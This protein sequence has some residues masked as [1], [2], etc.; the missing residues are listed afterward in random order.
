MTPAQVL[1]VAVLDR[2][3]RK[4][5][6]KVD[7]GNNESYKATMSILGNPVGT[8]KTRIITALV[9]L[10]KDTPE[11]M[12]SNIS[13]NEVVSPLLSIVKKHDK[14]VPCTLVHVGNDQISVQ[15][16]RSAKLC[17]LR[18][19]TVFQQK[20]T[21]DLLELARQ[22]DMLIVRGV[23]F[24]RLLED[25]GDIHWSMFVYD[26]PDC[27]VNPQFKT[28]IPTRFHMLVT[29][30]WDQLWDVTY[31]RYNYLK[32][33]GMKEYDQ[34]EDYLQYLVVCTAHEL[35]MPV[36]RTHN[37]YFK[38]S[39]ADAMLRGLFSH[40]VDRLIDS[41]NWKGVANLLGSQVT[42]KTLP[43]VATESIQAELDKA[44]ESGNRALKVLPAFEEGSPD[45]QSMQRQ[46]KKSKL[47][48]ENFMARM[49]ILK[50][51]IVSHQNDGCTICLDTLTNATIT[52]CH[53]MFCQ[54]CIV[55]WIRGKS[56][57][58]QTCPNC[59]EPITAKTLTTAFNGKDEAEEAPVA[60]ELAEE[61]LVGRSQAVRYI[62]GKEKQQKGKFKPKMLLFSNDGYSMK[63]VSK[64]LTEEKLDVRTMDGHKTT[65]RN[66]LN[67]YIEGNASVLLLNTSVDGA[68]LDS[69][70]YVTTSIVFYHDVTEAQ[71]EQVIG[72]VFRMGRPTDMPCNIYQILRQ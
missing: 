4:G 32:R 36:P 56:D 61:S 68:G 54:M 49:K 5:H 71:K 59:R 57:R 64:E 65:R 52:P 22:Y 43:E 21:V 48:V 62:L 46:I 6:A 23:G 25:H 69:L 58:A 19:R 9:A 33:I 7:I 51:R 12:S 26:E 16:E 31:S 34:V 28:I 66:N 17:G 1:A 10:L 20:D 63:K 50:E 13:T 70:Q 41:E 14:A 29:A 18:V 67:D 60:P 35:D 39:V 45:Y 11:Y 3:Y 15:W 55:Q 37:V 47:D 40:D 2:R 44:K 38:P 72:R 42:K 53:H 30:T 8:G 27:H 24:K